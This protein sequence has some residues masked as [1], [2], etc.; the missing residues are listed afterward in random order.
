MDPFSATI[1]PLDPAPNCPI[2]EHVA[3]M[4]SLEAKVYNL[5]EWQRRQ[6][7][8]LQHLDAKLD[9]LVEVV[10]DVDSA[11]R[12][13]TVSTKVDALPTT[14]WGAVW[15][16]IEKHAAGILIGLVLAALMSGG[17]LLELIS[18]IF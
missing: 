4:A 10:H 17:K 1:S 2:P 5:E 18:K 13:L 7:G 14:K 11:V 16:V 15:R 12:S 6:N 3:T 8:T 9:H